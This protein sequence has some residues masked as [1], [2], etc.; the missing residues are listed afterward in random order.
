MPL[1]CWGASAK[2]QALL[3]SANCPVEIARP[4]D[5]SQTY[6]HKRANHHR[7][8]R[9]RKRYRPR[10]HAPRELRW[11]QRYSR[12]QSLSRRLTR[13]SARLY[14]DRR[15]R[16]CR[17]RL[18]RPAVCADRRASGRIGLARSFL[19]KTFAAGLGLAAM[20]SSN[21]AAAQSNCPV[22]GALI[23]GDPQSLS[24][25]A[26]TINGQGSVDVTKSGVTGIIRGAGTCQLDSPEYG[27]DLDC[28]WHFLIGSDDQANTLFAQLRSD[29]ERCLSVTLEEQVYPPPS[30]ERLAE[31]EREYGTSFVETVQN[32]Q[33]IERYNAD[34]ATA[35]G[36]DLTISLRM[37]RHAEGP[38]TTIN[39]NLYR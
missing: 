10:R 25:V 1:G 39:L 4:H 22:I 34:V 29:L 3:A 8:R 12:G 26:I 36:D 27:V 9:F 2:P 23:A 33:H 24:G 19:F 6:E 17:L 30:P 38:R 20:A 16:I 11:R 7:T 15:K 5:Y 32:T 37:S 18:L 13:A 14:G 21:S 28:D 35:T 31:Y